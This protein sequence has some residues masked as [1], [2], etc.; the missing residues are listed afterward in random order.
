MHHYALRITVQADL[1]QCKTVPQSGLDTG[2]VFKAVD[3]VHGSRSSGQ[4]GHSHALGHRGRSR[5]EILV[6]HDG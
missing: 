2:R 3:V 4:C 1:G 5:G 6:G